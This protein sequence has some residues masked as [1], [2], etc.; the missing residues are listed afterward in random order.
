MAQTDPKHPS[1]SITTSARCNACSS[2]W[3]PGIRWMVHNARRSSLRGWRCDGTCRG[4]LHCRLALIEFDRFDPSRRVFFFELLS[5][6]F[7]AKAPPSRCQPTIC[8]QSHSRRTTSFTLA[9]N[10]S[11]FNITTFVMQW[12]RE[13][14]GSITSRWKPTLQIYS[15]RR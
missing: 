5:A 2:S 12:K 14:Y 4:W 7:G 1:T 3:K 11:T 9:L 8:Q 10:I 15:R 6:D 13:H